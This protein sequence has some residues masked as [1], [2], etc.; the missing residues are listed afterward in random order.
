MI[1]RMLA[2]ITAVLMIGVTMQVSAV[3]DTKSINNELSFIGRYFTGASNSDGGIAEIVKFNSETGRMYI[4]NGHIKSID[5]VDIGGVNSSAVTDLVLEKRID[6]SQLA[7]DYGFSCGD[8]TSV[9][10]NTKLDIIS[11]AVQ[12]EAYSENGYAVIMDYEG[13]YIKHLSTGVQPDMLTFTPDGN[14]LLTANEGEPREGYS[15]VNTIIDPKGSV[16]IVDLQ[17][18]VENAVAATVDFTEF[19]GNREELVFNGVLLKPFALPS[20]DLE[21]EYI[22]VSEDSEKAYISLQEA[23]SVAVLNIA[24]KRFESVNGL[25]FKDHTLTGN[26][27]DILKDGKAELSNQDFLGVYM[28]DGIATV[29]INGINYVLTANEGDAREWADYEDSDSFKFETGEKVDIIST[30]EKE[31]LNENK[32]Y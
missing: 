26:E 7:T 5:I 20:N 10:V 11:V 27:I 14:Y 15:D 4:V 18:G 19:D 2:G 8:I 29:D 22:A 30:P 23:N 16:T 9:S 17:G 24:E 21:P 31:G 1:K 3:S 32:K 25:G 6:F 13:N 28:P 12:N